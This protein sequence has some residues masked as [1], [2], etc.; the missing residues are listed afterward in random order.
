MNAATLI[1]SFVVIW[2]L[3]FF[4]VLPLRLT[5]QGEAGARLRGTS[6]SAPARA[7]LRMKALI[8]AAAAA[9]IWAAA[10]GALASGLVTPPASGAPPAPATAE[11]PEG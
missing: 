5:T 2:F 11:G 6:A 8:A 10:I 1:G 9:V 3:C 7:G 4:V